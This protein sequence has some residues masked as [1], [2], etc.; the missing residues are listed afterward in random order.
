MTTITKPKTEEVF[1][2]KADAYNT[3][4]FF[5]G[6][7]SE[8]GADALTA[9]DIAFAQALLKE[10]VVRSEQMGYVKAIFSTALKPP[11]SFAVV[12]RLAYQVGKHSVGVNDRRKNGTN[13]KDPVIYDSVRN[14]LTRSFRSTWNIRLQTGELIY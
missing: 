8:L 14:T 12:A 4:S 7:P 9:D 3:L 11:T 5:F 2:T 6:T 10:A 1:F 13:M